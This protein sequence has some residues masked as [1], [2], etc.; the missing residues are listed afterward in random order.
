M[1]CRDLMKKIP[2]GFESLSREAA[3]R[4][5]ARRKYFENNS[6]GCIERQVA[7]AMGRA[8]YRGKGPGPGVRDRVRLDLVPGGQQDV[9]AGRTERRL[10]QDAGVHQA[11]PHGLLARQRAE[12]RRLAAD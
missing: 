3:L 4:R 8:R 6:F 5:L 2:A 1:G 12:L 9:V 10:A 7:V 11:E